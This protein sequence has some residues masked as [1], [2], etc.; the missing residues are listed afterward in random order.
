VKAQMGEKSNWEDSDDLDLMF[1]GS[2]S[3]NYYRALQRYV[4]HRFRLKQGWRKLFKG[5]SYVSRRY[6][7]LIPYNWFNAVSLKRKLG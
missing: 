7:I 2:F 3:P 6:V 4:H 5:R 1:E